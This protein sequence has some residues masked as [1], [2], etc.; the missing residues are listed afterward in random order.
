LETYVNE[1]R[2][3]EERYSRKGIGARGKSAETEISKQKMSGRIEELAKARDA[4]ILEPEQSGQIWQFG[5]LMSEEM[6][7]RVILSSEVTVFWS[8][9]SLLGST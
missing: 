5:H 2:K 7:Q 6:D 3:A 4:R 9:S 8:F 1:D